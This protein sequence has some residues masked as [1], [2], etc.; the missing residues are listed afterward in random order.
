MMRGMKLKSHL[1][2]QERLIGAGKK[3]RDDLRA[4]LRRKDVELDDLRD[5]SKL[6][7]CENDTHRATIMALRRELVHWRNQS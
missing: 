7:S 1:L 3:A 4:A 5:R 6:I 2:K